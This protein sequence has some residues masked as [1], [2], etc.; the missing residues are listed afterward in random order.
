MLYKPTYL[1]SEIISDVIP[2]PPVSLLVVLI[3]M[4]LLFFIA[5][6]FFCSYGFSR[7]LKRQDTE[8]KEIIKNLQK[9]VKNLRD[10][11]SNDATI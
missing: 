1:F 4:G 8:N 2:N 11:K 3:G 7:A 9:Q 6:L 10:K 5:F